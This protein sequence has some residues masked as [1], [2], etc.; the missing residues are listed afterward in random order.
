LQ[1]MSQEKKTDEMLLLTGL[2]H[3]KQKT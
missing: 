2:V 1:D 3:D